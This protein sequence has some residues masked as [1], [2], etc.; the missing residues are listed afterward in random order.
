[1]CDAVERQNDFCNA[2]HLPDGGGPLHIDIRHDF[3]ARPPHNL[4]GLHALR[5]READAPPDPMRCIDCHGG[6]GLVGQARVKMLAARDALVW[7]SGDFEE[8]DR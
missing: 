2:C 1:M 6:V 8:P 3:D 4:A 7:L 5:V